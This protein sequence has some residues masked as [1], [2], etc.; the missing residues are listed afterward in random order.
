M[1]KLQVYC[2]FYYS[3][4]QIVPKL[5]FTIPHIHVSGMVKTRGREGM[6]MHES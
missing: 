5:G 4:Q 3:K 2:L 1:V 6:P